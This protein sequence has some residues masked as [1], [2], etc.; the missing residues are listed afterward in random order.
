MY[1]AKGIDITIL[2]GQD[3]TKNTSA[4]ISHS[5][6]SNPIIG[7]TTAI[8]IA[9]TITIGVYI[10]ENFVINSSVFPLLFCAS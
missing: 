4:L 8:S 7:G 9:R 1:N 2:Q 5:L 10:F 3:A 6:N